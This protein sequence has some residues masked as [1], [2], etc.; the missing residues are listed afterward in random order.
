MVV[1]YCWII[2]VTSRASFVRDAAM[3]AVAPHALKLPMRLAKRCSPFSVLCINAL[4]PSSNIRVKAYC[5]KL[6]STPAGDIVFTNQTSRVTPPILLEL[7]TPLRRYI[8]RGEPKAL[9]GVVVVFKPIS[10]AH[11]ITRAFVT[12]R[13]LAAPVEAALD[14]HV[15]T[16]VEVIC[17]CVD[18]LLA[19]VGANK[20]RVVA[21]LAPH[22]RGHRLARVHRVRVGG[23]V[24]VEYRA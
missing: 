6:P 3:S 8:R 18:P 9:A 19:R 1:P 4:E 20:S 11:G 24:A 10:P 2:Y 16:G 7:E 13:D 22:P 12:G 23:A 5:N 14:A 21:V 15:D 17:K